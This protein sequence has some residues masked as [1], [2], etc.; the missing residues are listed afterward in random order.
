MK[1]NPRSLSFRLCAWYAA[2]CLVICGAIATGSYFWLDQYLHSSLAGTLERRAAQISAVWRAHATSSRE[3]SVI[4]DIKIGYAPEQNDR[5]IR[6]STAKG[7]I[8][9][10]SGKPIDASFNPE[11]IPLVP[12]LRRPIALLPSQNMLIASC[13]VEANGK[14][15]VVETGAS[16]D[17]LDQVLHDYLAM[18][19]LG[20]PTM[21]LVAG[22]GGLVLVRKSLKPVRRIIGAAQD[23]S[24]HNLQK[25]LPIANTGDELENLSVVLN[26]MIARLETAF[27][28]SK[29]FTALASHELR[30]P[31]AIIL[32]D[33]EAALRRDDID[34]ETRERILSA[35]EEAE[36]LAQIVSGLFAISRL[37]AGEAF[38]ESASVDLS[39]LV[40]GTSEQ[41]GLMAE[42][43]NLKVHRRL[44]LGLKVMGDKVRLKQM[45]VNLMD[46]AI[47]YSSPGGDIT[48]ET[49]LEHEDVLFCVTDSGCGIDEEAIPHVF[50]SF[51]RAADDSTRGIDG[52]GLGLAIVRSITL[53]HRGKVSIANGTCGGCVATI[54]IPLQ[55]ESWT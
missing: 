16:L 22:I 28:H 11:Q 27:E 39:E 40:L 29:R 15:Y 50:E 53:A 30:T 24:Y 19:A 43:K 3:Q 21:L 52:A 42:E 51:Y 20:V 9:Y 36:H 44:E 45:I 6:I 54:K 4:D 14:A 46:N 1:I 18:L 25:R 55:K 10:T 5:F 35:L 49:R 12:R 7:T 26:D 47:K 13:D 38:M 41:M 23:I 32:G 17:P 8:L 37:E 48:L 34:S 31:I 2:F 33:L